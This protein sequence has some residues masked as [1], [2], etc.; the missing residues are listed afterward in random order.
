M[1][2]STRDIVNRLLE[3]NNEIEIVNVNKNEKDENKIK[4]IFDYEG[5]NVIVIIDEKGEAFSRAK[6]SQKF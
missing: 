3:K 4:N 2:K 1:V 5:N 6:T